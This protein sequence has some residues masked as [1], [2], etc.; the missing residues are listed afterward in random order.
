MEKQTV[1]NYIFSQI[2]A[3]RKI[4]SWDDT[5]VVDLLLDLK[6]IYLKQEKEQI[7]DAYDNNKMGRVN[8]GEQYYN[9]TYGGQDD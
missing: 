1:I 7:V 2:E 4:K 8:H 6:D 9:E 3:S 5:M